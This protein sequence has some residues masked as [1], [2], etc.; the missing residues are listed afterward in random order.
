MACAIWGVASYGVR[1][2]GWRTL[3]KALTQLADGSAGI[4]SVPK[5]K[6]SVCN[7]MLNWHRRCSE[8]YKRVW[9]TQKQL[10]IKAMS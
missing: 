8:S 9:N 6:L 10:R 4:M 5:A 7:G 3:G 2:P 1:H